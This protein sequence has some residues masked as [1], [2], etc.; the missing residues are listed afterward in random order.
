MSD[1]TCR[2][3]MVAILILLLLHIIGM[4]YDTYV[5]RIENRNRI[6]EKLEAVHKEIRE[7]P[8]PV[9]YYIGNE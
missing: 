3:V 5:T 2:R 4:M 6:M 8:S 7:K 9:T 1:K